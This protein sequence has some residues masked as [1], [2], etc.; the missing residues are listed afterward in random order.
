MGYGQTGKFRC[1][2]NFCMAL[3]SF[4]IPLSKTSLK[5]KHVKGFAEK[6]YFVPVSWTRLVNIF[7]SR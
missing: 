2:D 7:L 5:M 6:R 3:E 1:T 4:V